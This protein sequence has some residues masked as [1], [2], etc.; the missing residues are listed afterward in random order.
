MEMSPV[1]GFYVANWTQNSPGSGDA[2][3]WEQTG[4]SVK[5]I[6]HR[7]VARDFRRENP[8]K[9]P[10]SAVAYLIVKITLTLSSTALALI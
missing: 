9:L 5:V 1:F 8:G 10:G 3:M 2:P 6:A 4:E 7:A